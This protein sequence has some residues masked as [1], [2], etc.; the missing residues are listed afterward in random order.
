MT[1]ED[2][3]QQLNDFA[4]LFNLGDLNEERQKRAINRAI[5]YY[6]RR[7]GLPCN[8][9]TY[10]IA[11][12][13]GNYF[14][15]LPQDFNEIISVEYTDKNRNSEDNSF[16]YVPDDELMKTLGDRVYF[17]HNVFSVV[18][19]DGTQ[20][21]IVVAK[22]SHA[23]S[24][25]LESFDKFIDAT[26]LTQ[27]LNASTGISTIL[28]DNDRTKKTEGEAS[29]WLKITAS[30]D[31]PILVIP[32]P[33]IIIPPI[34]NDEEFF[35]VDLYLPDV[36]KLTNIELSFDEGR[37]SYTILAQTLNADYSQRKNGWNTIKFKKRDI[38]SFDLSNLTNVKLKIYL[39]ILSGQTYQLW[40]DNF[41]NHIPDLID[42]VYYSNYK[43]KDSSGN[44]VLNLQN[45]TDVPLF[46]SI[47]PD[48]ILP[49]A[50]R[51]A[52]YLTPQLK[53]NVEFTTL[54]FQEAENVIRNLGRAYP[55]KRCI[56]Y[57]KLKFSLT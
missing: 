36:S 55:R 27:I 32:L 57:G 48:L 49:I 11:Y 1:L 9:F 21:A 23:G 6:Q 18:R 8:E 26:K 33:D 20:R 43:G 30:A 7:L 17:T 54:F 34:S 45:N 25:L 46:D 15:T 35:S 16:R 31:N 2:I 4:V 41:R 29:A 42:I 14:Y 5:E 37:T 53:T 44:F 51:A 12:Y 3:L 52:F 13:A 28:G 24:N 10:Q 38:E 47:A 56:T 22:D 39:N 19:R 50:L 40:I